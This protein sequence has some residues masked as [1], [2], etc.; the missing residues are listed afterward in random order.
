[1][2]VPACL[3]R[4][5]GPCLGQGCYGGRTQ[6]PVVLEEVAKDGGLLQAI[7]PKVQP[8]PQEYRISIICEKTRSKEVLTTVSNN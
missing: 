8:A 4:I 5:F 3:C 6:I 7:N 1:M 2:A